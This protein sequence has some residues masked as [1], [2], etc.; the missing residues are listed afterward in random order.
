MTLLKYWHPGL[1]HSHSLTQK[2]DFEQRFRELFDK[3]HVIESLMS[4]EEDVIYVHVTET[5]NNRNEMVAGEPMNVPSS[6][7]DE[8]VTEKSVAVEE[9]SAPEIS[10]EPEPEFHGFGEEEQAKAKLQTESIV[11]VSDPEDENS[12]SAP[13][14]LP[15]VMATKTTEEPVEQESEEHQEGLA[16]RKLYM[17]GNIGCDETAE[18]AATFKVR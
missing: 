8:Q 17:C 16:G 18:T 10:K 12:A 1:H 7:E 3:V 5:E 14:E 11:I 4:P 13:I 2:I 9:N 6:L 15:E